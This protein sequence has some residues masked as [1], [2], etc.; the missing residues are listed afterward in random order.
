MSELEVLKEKNGALC[1][2]IICLKSE[3]EKL[4]RENELLE[5]DVENYRTE[6]HNQETTMAY[7]NGQLPV[8]REFAERGQAH[9]SNNA[10]HSFPTRLVLCGGTNMLKLLIGGS[11]FGEA[12]DVRCEGWR[13]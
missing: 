3:F 7:L 5:N 6:L 2:E 8:Y 12:F 9:E 10:K 13:I 1:D 11:P 4:R